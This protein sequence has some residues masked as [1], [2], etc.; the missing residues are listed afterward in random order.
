MGSYAVTPTFN[1]GDLR[2]SIDQKISLDPPLQRGL[3][4]SKAVVHGQGVL[5]KKVLEDI[6]SGR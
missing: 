2:G 6:V 3:G 1:V 4:V 5:D